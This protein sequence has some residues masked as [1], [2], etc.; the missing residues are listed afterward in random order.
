MGYSEIV[1]SIKSKQTC[2]NDTTTSIES[3]SFDSVWSGG[4]HDTLTSS[5]KTIINNLKLQEASLTSF[6]TGLTLLQSY[7]DNKEKISA[8]QSALNCLTD[9][10]EYASQRSGLLSE[11]N[12]INRINEQLKTNII[13]IMNSISSV[14]STNVSKVTIDFGD[15]NYMYDLDEIRQ[16]YK[17]GL[18]KLS[19]GVSLYS[20]YDQYD[21]NGN[22]VLSGK[23]YVEGIIIGIQEQYS[24]REAVVNSAL[25]MLQLVADKGVKLDY[26]HKG[27]M[28]IEP[29]VPT[30]QVASGVD[31]NPFASWCVDKGTNGGFQWRPVGEFK[32]VGEKLEDWAQAQ[33][34]DVFVSDG[35]VGIIIENNPETGE[36]ICAEASGSKIG[37][38]TQTRTYNSL[39]STGYQ[40]RDMTSVYDGTQ[41]TNRAIFDQYVDWDTYERKV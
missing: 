8:L 2:I 38:I 33:P 31:C 3:I 28:G 18:T 11:I 27:T 16:M 7:K 21:E 34:G 10:E 19:D 24:G 39:K 6:C 37:I 13:S 17:S 23:D 29:Y 4:A 26:E 32:N 14:D 40:V 30:A 25:A 12:S 36:F 1:S 9:T 35:H 20:Y 15:L 41:N 5:L 22:L